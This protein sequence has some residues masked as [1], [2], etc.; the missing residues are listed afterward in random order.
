MQKSGVEICVL[1]G[2]FKAPM[3]KQTQFQVHICSGHP[4]PPKADEAATRL[5][6]Q[7]QFTPFS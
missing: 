7:S 1:L 5:K 2:N 4:H 6:K 3:E